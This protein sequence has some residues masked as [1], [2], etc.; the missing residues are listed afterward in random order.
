MKKVALLGTFFVMPAKAGISGHEHMHSGHETPASAGVAS[1]IAAPCRV[2]WKKAATLA[3]VLW[4]TNTAAMAGQGGASSCEPE[5]TADEGVVTL[6][7]GA[8][9]ADC[10]E[11]AG[12]AIRGPE[13]A[14]HRLQLS[15]PLAAK[16]WQVVL[17]LPGPAD[18]TEGVELVVDDGEPMRVP[19]EFLDARAQ[20][21]ALVIR[22]EVVGVV[23]KALRGG[24]RLDWR[25][26]RKGGAARAARF[27]I[28]CLPALLK[29]ADAQLAQMRAMRQLGK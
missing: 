21:R 20:G 9:E 1:K 19:Y 4:L 2:V 23:V 27:D 16:H 10:R 22:P 14:G 6:N 5:R 13:A 29:A 25:Y 28:S 18:A 8:W 24:H 26:T 15:R 17:S 7:A 3:L 11:K 12:C